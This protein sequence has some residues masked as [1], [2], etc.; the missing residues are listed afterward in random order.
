MRTPR[1]TPIARLDQ[2]R[3]LASPAR[4]E[5]V[6]ALTRLGTASLAELGVALG[7]PADGLYYHVRLLARVGLVRAA[8]T[9]MRRGR[10]EELFRTGARQFRVRYA[11]G[12][13]PRA[14]AMDAIVASMLRL[15]IRDFR[16]AQRSG[17]ARVEGPARDLWALRTV[18]RLEEAQ[19][20]A[21]NRRIHDLVGAVNGTQPGGRLYAVTVLLT[22]LAH[23][24][25]PVRRRAPGRTRS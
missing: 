17:T 24:A 2:M 3:V 8:G 13:A 7:R 25:G 21:V 4:Q 1:P 19:V 16:R 14:R 22:P 20:R 18:G 6:D 15:G 10:R 12:S 23:R 9:R 11:A 5:L